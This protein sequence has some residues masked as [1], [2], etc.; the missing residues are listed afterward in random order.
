MATVVDDIRPTQSTGSSNTTGTIS[1]IIGA[2]VDV[3][4]PD[5]LPA[6][7]STRRLPLLSVS[8]AER[9]AGRTPSARSRWTR[10]RD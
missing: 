10:P 1:Q 7:S 8:S 9:I 4:F 5:N 2:V 3:H 6:T